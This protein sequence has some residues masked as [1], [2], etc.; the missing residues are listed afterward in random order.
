MWTA[1]GKNERIDDW[2]TAKWDYSAERQR[3]PLRQSLLARLGHR[4]HRDLQ[5]PE[6]DGTLAGTQSVDSDHLFWGFEDYGVTAVAEIR[7]PGSFEYAVG[8]DYQ[9]FWGED[10][11]WLI[12]DK[13]ETAQAVYGQ[14]RTSQRAA[15][16]HEP[17]V[18]PA[19]QHDE[20]HVRRHRLELQR[21][22][23]LQ[24]ELLPARPGR[25]VVPAAGC[26]GALLDATA[27]RSA[28]RTSSPRRARTSRSRSAGSRPR[29]TG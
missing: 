10:E 1:V 18:R 16:E 15:R 19:L 2:I 3:G 12:E 6:P 8:Y 26:R 9:R 21:P 29:A 5:R 24:P 14:I 23:R 13:T 20:R 7:S 22:A 25:H 27:A 4:V 17:R 11:V 28:I